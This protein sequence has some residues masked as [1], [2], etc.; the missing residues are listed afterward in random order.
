MKKIIIPVIAMVAITLFSFTV[1]N[2]ACGVTPVTKSQY[3]I[4][5]VNCLTNND[6]SSISSLISKKYGMKI[7]ETQDYDLDFTNSRAAE[8]IKVVFKSKLVK[9]KVRARVLVIGATDDG[10]DDGGDED[11]ERI[12]STLLKYSNS[13]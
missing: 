10:G 9:R 11:I 8:G 6:V 7:S 2:N 3:E 5:D 13:K 1:K 12:S 4:A